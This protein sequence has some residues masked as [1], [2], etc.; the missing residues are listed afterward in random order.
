LILLGEF[1]DET[2][3]SAKILNAAVFVMSHSVPSIEEEEPFRN[4]NEAER[5]VRSVGKDGR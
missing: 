1:E 4:F 5:E 2:K 3:D